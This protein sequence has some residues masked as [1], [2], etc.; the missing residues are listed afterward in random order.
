MM[1]KLEQLLARAEIQDCMA[2]YARGVDR[3]DWAA[4]R[5]TYHDDAV[6][7]HGAFSGPVDTFIDWVSKRQES[8][9]AAT[10]FLGNSLIEFVDDNTAAVETYYIA[11]QR[12]PLLDRAVD[13]DVEVLGR[14]VDLFEKR[15][16]A[17]KVQ[18]R[19]VVYDTS[20]TRGATNRTRNLGSVGS[21]DSSDPIYA[22]L[23]QIGLN[24]R[25]A[26]T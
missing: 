1:D 2:R 26:V 16:G 12:I 22:L 17:W 4:V 10:H 11:T 21:R 18:Q 8:V 15:D 23:E 24:R 9:P 3:R 13:L 6:D 7:D 20:R 5:A 14:Y 19:R 25:Q